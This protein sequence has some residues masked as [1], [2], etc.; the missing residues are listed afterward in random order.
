MENRTF[1]RAILSYFKQSRRDQKPERNRKADVENPYIKC[2][3]C[4]NSI[5]RAEFPKLL[6]CCPY[7]GYHFKMS[8]KERLDSVMDNYRLIHDEPSATNPIKFPQYERKIKQIRKEKGVDEA[9]MTAVG[10][11]DGCAAVVVAMETGFLMASMGTYVGEQITKAFE[12]AG[13]CKLPVIIFAA[14]GGARMQEGIYSLMQMAKTALA[15][16]K[17]SDLGLLYVS[18][19]TNPT[20]GGVSASFA[21][22][23]DIIIAEPGALIGFAGPRVIQQTVRQELPKGFQSSEYLLE[24]GFL[25]D[26]VSRKDMKDYLGRILKLHAGR[27]A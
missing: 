26:V 11:V 21:S 24:N 1:T 12:Y 25:D 17:H 6:R 20:T 13:E 2:E 10:N 15:V 22:L 27:I 19:L 3:S 8:A 9:L 14:S 4:G 7:C 23:G 16:R 18:V 5:L